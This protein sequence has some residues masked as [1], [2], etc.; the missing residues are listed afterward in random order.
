M[1]MKQPA[2]KNKVDVFNTAAPDAGPARKLHGR[3]ASI[4]MTLPPNQI[5]GA[6][7]IRAAEDRARSR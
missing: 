4:A 6:D 2:R 7:A 5:D 1:A 3:K